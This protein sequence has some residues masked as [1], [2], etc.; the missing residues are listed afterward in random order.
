MANSIEFKVL[1]GVE[2]EKS[3]GKMKS[4]SAKH[5]KIALTASAL[6]TELGK[7]QKGIAIPAEPLK[8]SN[9]KAIEISSKDVD[10]IRAIHESRT[11]TAEAIVGQKM[12]PDKVIGTLF[13]SLCTLEFSKMESEYKTRLAAAKNA[14]SKAQVD[15]EWSNVVKAASMAFS[16]GG[17]KGV[18]EAKLKNFSKELSK[19]K[20]NFT[21]IVNIANR[22]TSIAGKE[23]EDLV[24]RTVLKGGFLVETGVLVD[25]GIVTTSIPNLCSKPFAEGSFTKHFHKEFNLTVRIP[26]W[27]PKWSNPFKIC[28]KNVV[29]AGVS[30]DLNVAVGYKLTCCGATAYGQASAQACGTLVGITFCAGCS[31]TITGVAGIG[32][33]GT[34]NN[35]TYGLGINAQLK[36][37]F[38]GVTVLNLQAPFGFNVSAPCPPA[39][40]CP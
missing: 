3:V 5:P 15:K 9:I 7:W 32:R 28:H 27:C 11:P 18:T 39:G 37:K 26:Y 17:L 22:G 35:C 16:S 23:G 13:T 19:S 8:L 36:C 1:S 12:S 40:L 21:S 14:A 2:L 10:G 4:F 31:A 34:G 24:N 6:Q 33:T 30:F 25:P 20:S 29:L 38:G